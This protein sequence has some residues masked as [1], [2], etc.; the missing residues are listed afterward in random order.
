MDLL[1]PDRT[2]PLLEPLLA[3]I[4]SEDVCHTSEGD[5]TGNVVNNYPY[6]SLKIKLFKIAA[7]S[8]RANE[9]NGCARAD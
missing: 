8:T 2:K 1:L 7:A 4:M 5:F 9:L 3:W 6:M